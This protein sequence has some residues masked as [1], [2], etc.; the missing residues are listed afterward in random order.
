MCSSF[1]IWDVTT[2]PLTSTFLADT[3]KLFQPPPI[4][5]FKTSSIC[6]LGTYHSSNPTSQYQNLSVRVLQ[7]NRTIR[8]GVGMCVWRDIGKRREAE[9]GRERQWYLERIGSHDCGLWEVLSS[10]VSKLETQIVQFQS[11]SKSVRPRRADGV[12]LAYK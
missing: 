2:W 5:S 8:V 10:E 9:K 3:S 12:V 11:E 7:R 6:L 4:T 1:P